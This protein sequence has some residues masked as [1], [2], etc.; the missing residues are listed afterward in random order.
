MARNIVTD[1]STFSASA[2]TGPAA[3]AATVVPADSDL[4]DITR[5]IY[6]GGAGNL[7]VK[8]AGNAAIVVFPSV[9]AG[10]VLPIRASQIRSTGTN[11]TNIVA[12][13]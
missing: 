6:V 11:A 10:T 2:V 8:M 13:W 1:P 4:S 7:A 5:S 9:V 3:N 12:M